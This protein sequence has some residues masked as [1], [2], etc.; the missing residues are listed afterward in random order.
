MCTWY[1]DA[2]DLKYALATRWRAVLVMC[3]DLPALQSQEEVWA[4]EPFG[5]HHRCAVSVRSAGLQVHADE[6]A[7]WDVTFRDP[8]VSGSEF[9]PG[10]LGTSLP[11]WQDVIFGQSSTATRYSVVAPVRSE[12]PRVFLDSF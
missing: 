9:M 11:F 5:S 6:R 10:S 3:L 4:R 7:P 1:V 8:G 2:A 12:Y